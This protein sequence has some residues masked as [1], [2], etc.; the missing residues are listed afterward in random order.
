LS[1]LFAL[2]S[3]TLGSLGSTSLASQ[4]WLPRKTL[5]RWRLSIMANF[6]SY[7]AQHHSSHP[8]LQSHQH[9]AGRSRRATRASAAHHNHN[10]KQARALRLQREA[11][12]LAN[13]RAWAFRQ[14]FEAARSFDF[15]DDELF[16]PFN[17]LTDD[18]VSV[19]GLS[20]E[21]LGI[22]PLTTLP[23]LQSM[24]SGSD[25]S[26]LSS[27]SPEHSPL[28][29]QIQPT[30]SFLLPPSNSFPNPSYQAQ[31]QPKLHQP[32]AQR[33]GPKA[34]PIVDPSTRSVASPPPSVPSVSPARQ[35]MQAQ[36]FIPAA[37][38]RAAW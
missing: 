30:P 6:Y 8:N 20:I 3:S 22:E 19:D 15:E 28:Q 33:I 32:L 24:H 17:L 18:D 10:H 37:A 36:Q 29:Q 27:G 1:A 21:F 35:L 23:Q 2:R 12:E 11:E 4:L 13:E 14:T 31:S 9:H 7:G 38:R 26:S 34:I 5:Q 16:C 25:R